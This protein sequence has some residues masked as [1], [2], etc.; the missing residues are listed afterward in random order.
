MYDM[1]QWIECVSF[2]KTIFLLSISKWPLIVVLVR[3]KVRRVDGFKN[4]TGS[5]N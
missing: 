5:P 2:I 1:L 4:S 3:D